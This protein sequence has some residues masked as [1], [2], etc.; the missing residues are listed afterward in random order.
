MNRTMLA[1]TVASLLPHASLL[2]AQERSVDDTMVI[3][4]KS[5][6]N[7]SIKQLFCQSP[8][9]TKDDIAATQA[10]SIEEVLRRLPWY[11]DF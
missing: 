10:K 5:D 1:M 7:N 9:L 6:L 3:L 4:A 11:S 8:L 2:Y